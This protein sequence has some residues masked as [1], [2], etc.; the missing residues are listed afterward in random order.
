[1][2]L[3]STRNTIADLKRF[4]VITGAIFEEGFGMFLQKAKLSWAVPLE[5]KIRCYLKACVGM[6]SNSVPEEEFPIR[7]RKLLI[8]LGPT[9]VKFG[10]VLSLRPDILPSNLTTELAMLTNQVPSFPYEQVKILV[11][12]ELRKP[13]E[14]VFKEFDHEPLA[15]ASLA[16]V[17]KAILFDGTKVAVK[18]QRPGIRKMI[19]EDIDILRFLSGRMEQQIPEWGVYRP[20]Q[21]V[22]E[23][24]ETIG[25]ELDFTIEAV[26]AKR[27]GAMFADE[28]TVK[29][30]EVFPEY[31]SQSV[32]TMTLINGVKLDDERALEKEHVDKQILAQNGVNALLRQ[33]FVEGFFHADPHPGNY[34]A[35][36]NNV[37]AFIDYGMVGRLSVTDRR[38]LAAF[39]ISFLHRD[40]E[41][42]IKHLWHLVEVGP[43]AN[44]MSF[45]HDVDDILHEWFGAKLKDVSLARTFM[46]IMDSG[47]R[48]R[49]YFPSSFAY[50]GKSLLTTEAMG[51]TLDPEFDFAKQMQPYA[52]QILKMEVN[53]KNLKQK[54]QDMALDY[55]SYIDEGPEIIMQTLRKVQSGQLEV[56]INT[57]EFEAFG[58]AMTDEGTKRLTTTLI[59]SLFAV[60]IVSYL[61][62]NGLLNLH[63]N[64]STAAIVLL[65]LIGGWTIL[66]RFFS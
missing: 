43:N 2:K 48:N 27:F 55:Y 59:A 15:A 65:A 63:L 31:S 32:L 4:G 3:L 23:F 42:A 34:F 22:E 16:Q 37:F 17:H 29:V 21:L 9:F 62:A 44:K 12:K 58:K 36:P 7:L 26:H 49:I 56:K 41:S 5:C 20:R 52:M 24:A 10:Q 53:P 28:P 40:S 35:L 64:L 33:V 66:R 8:K 51:M 30:A 47:R 60:G 50:L 57:E 61:V 38:E 1:M 25:R 11:E 18:V 6:W 39:F 14:K 45:E 54:L 19:E 13:I 46:R